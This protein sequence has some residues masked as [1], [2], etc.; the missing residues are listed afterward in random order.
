MEM[1]FGKI[2]GLQ[3]GNRWYVYRENQVGVA[4][5]ANWIDF[6]I[7]SGSEDDFTTAAMNT[8]FLEFGPM[9]TFSLGNDM[10]L[11]AYYNLCPTM[12][13]TGG[14]SDGDD[15]TT[16]AYGGFGFTHALGAAFRY[17]V[18]NLGLEYAMGSIHS[19]G[20]ITSYSI[21]YTK[22]YESGF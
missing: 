4:I 13:I 3:L 6:S 21:H 2:L 11:D 7:T 19:A 1:G 18:F 8:S 20:V 22:L 12:L 10:A 17:K 14:V 5:M 16:L 15:E 9:G